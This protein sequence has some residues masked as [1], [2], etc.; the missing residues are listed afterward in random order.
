[1]T[2]SSQVIQGSQ[3]WLNLR[4]GLVTA[5]RIADVVA[6][7][8]SGPS[9]SR[10]NYRSQ[11]AVE[12]LTGTPDESFTN[13]AMQ[14]GT[15]TEPLARNAYESHKGLFVEQIGFIYHPTIKGSGSYLTTNS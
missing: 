9:A 2:D 4:C 1:M 15:E 6:K 8:K 12:I 5:S 13:A 7:T 3:E 10:A 14:W 11:L